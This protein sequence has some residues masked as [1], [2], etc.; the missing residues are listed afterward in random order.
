LGGV[1][2]KMAVTENGSKPARFHP[3]RKEHHGR[4]EFFALPAEPEKENG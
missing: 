3:V 1:G 2:Q 4:A